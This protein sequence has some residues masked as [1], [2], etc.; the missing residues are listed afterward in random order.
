[1]NKVVKWRVCQ[2]SYCK[3]GK[4]VVIFS[5]AYSHD[6]TARK[7]QNNWH[8]SDR[9]KHRSVWMSKRMP[10]QATANTEVYTS[11]LQNLAPILMILLTEFHSLKITRSSAYPLVQ[12]Q[13]SSVSLAITKNY[14]SGESI[15]HWEHLLL[16][17]IC[18]LTYTSPLLCSNH[19]DIHSY[20]FLY[21]YCHAFR[22]VVI[23]H[24]ISC[25]P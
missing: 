14:N 9:L 19:S 20:L 1:M 13:R 22:R 21:N 24:R 2:F 8:R 18:L 7:T 12:K 4:M 25:Q 6:R 3:R 15:P 23:R 10:V 16:T 17:V 11:I 5:L